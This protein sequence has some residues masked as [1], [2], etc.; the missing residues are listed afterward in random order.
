M[1]GSSA[2]D[3]HD[4]L[5]PDYHLIFPNWDASMARQAQSLDALVRSHL[6]P[7]A[8]RVLDC[9]CGIGTQAI[10]LAR[11]GPRVVGSDLSPVAAARAV[12]EAAARGGGSRRPRRTCARCRSRRPPSTPPQVTQTPDGKVITFQLWHWHEDGERYD[13]EHFQLIPTGNTW[14]VRARRTTT[15][16]VTTS[17][18]SRHGAEPL[19]GIARNPHALWRVV[20]D[21]GA[22]SRVARVGKSRGM[23]GSQWRRRR[24]G[25]CWPAGVSGGCR[26]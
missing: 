23:G 17:R 24:R 5:A 1:S 26:T 6:V 7:G 11:A 22:V 9:A 12:T 18:Y 13:Q 19:R 3:F 14:T 21:A 20:P 10:G 25:P 16:A 2:R 15:W 4:D 8:Q